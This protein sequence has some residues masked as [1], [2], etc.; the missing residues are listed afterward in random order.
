MTAQRVV[1]VGGGITGTMHAIEAVRR[2]WEVVHLEADAAPRRASVRNFGLIWVSGR[3]AGA[4][5]LLALRARTRWEELAR[6]VPGMGFRAHGSLTIAQHHSELALM[7]EVA[8]QDDAPSRGFTVLTAEEVREKNPALQ[9][10]VLGG[11]WCERDAIVEPRLVPGALRDHLQSSG[12]YHW[13]P[14]THVID[15]SS[16]LVTDHRGVAYQGDLVLLCIGDRLA[17]LGGA[18]G[19]GLAEAP[20]RPCRLDMMQ[21]A[22]LEATLTTAVA[23]ADS[24]RYYPAFD[25]PGRHD[26]IEPVA[27]TTEHGMQLLLV[28]RLDGGLTIGDT[29]HYEQPFDFAT[30][31]TLYDALAARAER[32]LGRP[33]PKILRRWAGVYTGMTDER[34]YLREEF[35]AGVWVVT[36]PAGRG[37]T[38][39][40]A[41]AEESWQE[42]ERA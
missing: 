37:M 5:L 28:Q 11:L 25:L 23:D 1:I 39:S 31:D 4:E 41:I 12:R 36:G 17:G 2:G 20:I 10:A 30:D 33:L 22:P 27:E 16:H 34:L 24:M 13:H 42:M 19:R 40:P 21:T 3:A 32:I 18:V 26:L 7:R 9:G 35:N 29:H 14:G 8:A 15:V 38:L 6:E